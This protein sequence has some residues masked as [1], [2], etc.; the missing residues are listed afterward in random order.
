MDQERFATAR[1]SRRNLAQLPIELNCDRFLAEDNGV[2]VAG[3]A[4]AG[5]DFA[6]ALG[7]VLARH[8][9]QSELRNL[10]R[11]GLSAVLVERLAQ[12]LHHFVAI[13][14]FRHV[15]EVDHDD[16]ANIAES[17]LA[18]DLISSFEVGLRDRVLKPCLTATTD[19]GAGVDVEDG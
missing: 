2:A 9:D 3:R 10:S 1:R 18:D 17:E 7:H 8:L 4:G 6:H 16:P 5:D 13:L 12:R 15:D 19:V 14:R 11:E